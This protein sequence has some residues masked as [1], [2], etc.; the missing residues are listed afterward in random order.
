MQTNKQNFTKEAPDEQGTKVTQKIDKKD[1]KQPEVDTKP[2]TEQKMPEPGVKDQSFSYRLVTL[3]FWTLPCQI[4]SLEV[5]DVAATRHLLAS[6]PGG[7]YAILTS[8]DLNRP[9]LPSEQ[10]G[11]VFIIFELTLYNY[12][13]C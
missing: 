6:Y 5:F 7:T 8:F 9:K 10:V 3:S 11:K 2:K 13:N 4:G 1:S 12:F